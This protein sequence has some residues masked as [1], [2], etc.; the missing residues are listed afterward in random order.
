MVYAKTE[1]LEAKAGLW[2]IETTRS[3][4]SRARRYSESATVIPTDVSANDSPSLR[5]ESSAN[6]IVQI[7]VQFAVESPASVR[8]GKPHRQ[9][10]VVQ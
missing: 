6:Q 7:L 10:H 8:S 5:D 9:A 3:S 1:T 2:T 4:D